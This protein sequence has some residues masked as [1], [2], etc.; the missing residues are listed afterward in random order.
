MTLKTTLPAKTEARLE[1]LKTVSDVVKMFAA[2]NIPFNVADN[3]HVRGHF[4]KNIRGGG[5][6]P[7]TDALKHYLT[8][9][10]TVEKDRLK[11]YVKNS[12]LRIFS[13]ETFDKEGWFVP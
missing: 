2:A 6:I 8:D 12:T 13:D 3:P 1:N 11:N 4:P 7:R 5:A 9:I 10:S